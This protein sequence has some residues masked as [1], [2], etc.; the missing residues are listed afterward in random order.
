M[1]PMALLAQLHDLA[2]MLLQAPNAQRA[3]LRVL[4]AM[5][6]VAVCCMCVY[7]LR[8]L[9]RRRRNSRFAVAERRTRDQVA[10]AIA[11]IGL[12]LTGLLLFVITRG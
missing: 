5:W 12:F 3:S 1:T 2:F 7:L 9:L 8:Q 11:A 4:T 10:L 6:L